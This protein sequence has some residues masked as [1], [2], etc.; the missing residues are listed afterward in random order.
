LTPAKKEDKEKSEIESVE[1]KAELFPRAF[2]GFT[3]TK[4]DL[5]S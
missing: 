4:A 5:C 2:L 1:T 3:V